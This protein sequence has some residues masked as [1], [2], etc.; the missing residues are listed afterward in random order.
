MANK[1]DSSRSA[2]QP[3]EPAEPAPRRQPQQSRSQETYS[4]IL[5]AAA[6]LFG[7]R[8]YEQTTTHQIAAKAGV[9]VG[10]LYR[11]FDSKQAIIHEL[12]VQQTTGLRERALKEFSLADL[13]SRDLGQLLR[14]TLTIVFRIYAERA[15]LRRVLAEQSRKIPELAAVKRSLEAEVHRAVRQILAAAPGATL[16]DVEVGAYLVSLFIESLMDDFVLYRRDQQGEFFDDRRV[17]EAAS[18]MVM[19]FVLGRVER[20]DQG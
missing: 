13:V 14:K 6:Q 8:G 11:Y 10:A 16:E 4:S 2:A 3:A 15:G 9:S 19:R 17:I 5:E 20:P 7:E 18:E 12:Y 1:D